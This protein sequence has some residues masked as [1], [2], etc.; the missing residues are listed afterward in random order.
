M[1]YKSSSD[2]GHV[3]CIG[4][5]LMGS[6]WAAHFLRAGRDVVA[7]DNNPKAADYVKATV[8]RA[9]PIVEALGLAADAS[10]ERLRVTDDLEDAL[11]GA[12]FVQESA[13][14]DEALKI[15][16]LSEVDALAADDV[17]IC[18]SSSGFL[19]ARLRSQCKRAAGRVMVGHPFNPP[20]LIPLVEVVSGEGANGNAVE[21]ARRFYE[22]VNSKPIVLNKDI[23]GYV[24]NR[25]QLALFREI[26]HLV[27]EDIASIADIDDAIA[28]G[29]GLRWA[30]FGPCQIFKLASQTPEQFGN[31][32]DLIVGEMDD[33][34]AIK[35]P[36]IK[37]GVR[38]KV[39]AGVVEAAG[40]RD[41]AD[42]VAERDDKII[43]LRK[44]LGV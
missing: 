10:T 38:E 8:E 41:Y 17:V 30:V 11:D 14:E 7:Y 35:E 9:W 32:L 40:D 29:P 28:Y 43:A 37:P 6:G 13:F 22:S 24:A 25:L 1:T 42:L 44:A 21:A 19:A 20:Y 3:A 31:F 27:A 18:S 16:L 26:L 4:V 5:G 39:I 23:E 12:V 36:H 33:F 2:A 15:G 34:V